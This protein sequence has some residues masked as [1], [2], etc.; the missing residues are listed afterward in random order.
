M[1]AAEQEG[2]RDARA[3]HSPPGAS[4]FDSGQFC[5]NEPPQPISQRFTPF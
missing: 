4:C 2:E 5:Q 1:A 3:V